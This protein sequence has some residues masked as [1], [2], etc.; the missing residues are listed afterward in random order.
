MI[1][2][3]VGCR[4]RLVRGR[5]PALGLVLILT[6]CAPAVRDA[7]VDVES[8]GRPVRLA[9]VG[10]SL[11]ANEGSWPEHIDRMLDERWEVRNF[12]CGGATALSF[13]DHPYATLMLPKVMAYQPDVVVVL[14]GTNDSK[15]RHWY[16][17]K[18]FERDYGQLLSDLEGLPT[19]PRIWICLPPPAFPGQW[20]I[21]EGRLS[22][23]RPVLRRIARRHGIPVIDLQAPFV[24]RSEW[25]P[26][27]I[28]PDARASAEMARRIC[29]A[30]TGAPE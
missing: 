25:F 28:H 2:M 13:G 24:D 18:E 6:A 9:C 5:G 29:R 17:K 8:Y 11:T 23:L 20:G 26:D 3:G 30:L 21:D 7:P 14:L 22:E 4:R 12:G 15:P 1:W 27:Q 19:R 10:D 16:Y